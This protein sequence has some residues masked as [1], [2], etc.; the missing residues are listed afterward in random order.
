MRSMNRLFTKSL[1]LQDVFNHVRFFSPSVGNKKGNIFFG[2][3]LTIDQLNEQQNR[4][5]G[6]AGGPSSENGQKSSGRSEGSGGSIAD[7]S[8][9]TIAA[10]YAIYRIGLLEREIDD[11]KKQ[12]AKLS[13][14][15]PDNHS[16]KV[17]V[18]GEH[19]GEH[20]E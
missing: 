4:P 14:D 18:T 19:S 3:G 11:L 13:P 5:N 10:F 9:T 17:T 2:S 1:P 16:T 20:L 15:I 6:G 7:V 12:V 8:W